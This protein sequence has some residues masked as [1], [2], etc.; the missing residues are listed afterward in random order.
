MLVAAAAAAQVA[1]QTAARDALLTRAESVD[2]RFPT[3]YGAAW[4]AI[5]RLE[6]TTSL[7]GGCAR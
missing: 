2:A 7:L 4:I 6:L 3:Y 1:G 5:G